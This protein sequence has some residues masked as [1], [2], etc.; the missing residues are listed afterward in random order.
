[1]KTITIGGRTYGEVKVDGSIYAV[2]ES[3]IFVTDVYFTP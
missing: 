1:M 2:V 3:D